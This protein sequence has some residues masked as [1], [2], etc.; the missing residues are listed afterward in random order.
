MKKTKALA[1]TAA[2]ALL[3]TGCDVTT[4]TLNNQ[5]AFGT[6]AVENEFLQLAY[7][8]PERVRD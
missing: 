3:A 5:G 8:T 2:I 4:G 7:Q 6:A 1:T